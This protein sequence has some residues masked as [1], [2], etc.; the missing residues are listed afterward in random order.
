MLVAVALLATACGSA[1][2]QPAEPADQLAPAPPIEAIDEPAHSFFFEEPDADE[3]AVGRQLI[4]FRVDG[5]D[6]DCKLTPAE[7]A[8]AERSEREFR[9]ATEPADDSKPRGIARLPVE[10]GRSPATATL[11]AWRTRSGKLC[12]LIDVADE[13]G[14]GGGGPTGPCAPG[15][16]KCGDICLER[17]GEGDGA[18][19]V[20]LLAG[21][22]WSGADE[23]RIEFIDGN[24]TRYP[25]VGPIVPEF[26]KARV[27]MLDLG[28]RLYRR[29]ELL[30]DGK[31]LDEVEVSQSEIDTELCFREHP[32][33]LPDD[34]LEPTTKDP[35][36]ELSACLSK[37]YPKED[38][39][40]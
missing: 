26:P 13:G 19:L 24:A 25:L 33:S 8:E 27:F 40:D 38:K 28:P 11:I 35:N 17:S 16:R 31:R 22:V 34:P 2:T 9:E 32:M 23:L 1:E 5:E 39:N 4:C 3:G 21:T 7:L 37:A 14:G 20:Y 29:L 15:T 12:T 18:D 30:E 10:S 6:E 36:P